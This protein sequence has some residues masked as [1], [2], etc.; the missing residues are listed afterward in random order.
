MDIPARYTQCE[1]YRG[2]VIA[3]HDALYRGFQ[4]DGDATTRSYITRA[5][6]RDAIDRGYELNAK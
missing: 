2:F 1:M 5:A 4:C 6:C 3:Y